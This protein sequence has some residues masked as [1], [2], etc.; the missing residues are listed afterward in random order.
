MGSGRRRGQD[1][2]LM[3]A[4]A[5]TKTSR[6]AAVVTAVGLATVLVIGLTGCGESDDRGS[7]AAP[8]GIGSEDSTPSSPSTEAPTTTSTLPPGGR[9]PTAED[10]LR[11]LL[12]GDSV[13]AGLA[14]AVT[15]AVESGGA[16]DAT[17]TLTPALPHQDLD[18]AGWQARLAELDPEVVVV[19]VGVW[20]R[21][22][23]TISDPAWRAGFDAG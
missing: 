7:S 2:G 17:F 5:R 10:P 13:M 1:E 3:G 18:W 14:P 8:G 4:W 22:F 11:V 20:E 23:G 19:L 9:V 16:A 21:T 15:A 6:R 12:A